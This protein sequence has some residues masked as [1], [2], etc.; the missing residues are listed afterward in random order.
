MG[1]GGHIVVVG[2]SGRQN[3]VV[4]L[5]VVGVIFGAVVELER[6]SSDE[7]VVPLGPATALSTPI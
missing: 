7:A 5:I 2:G 3:I 6:K 4:A 1:V